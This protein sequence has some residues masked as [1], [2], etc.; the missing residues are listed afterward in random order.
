ML[1]C[2]AW[3]RILITSIGVTT[4]TASVT[5][6]ARPAVQWSNQ[7]TAH[8]MV[9]KLKSKVEQ[10]A[11]S[12]GF[13]TAPNPPSFASRGKRHTKRVSQKRAEL[14]QERSLSS[15]MPLIISKHL[16]VRLKTRKSNR[17]LRYNPRHNS[18]QSLIQSQGRLSSRN[19]QSGSYEAALLR[20]W[21]PCS[22]RE[23]HTHFDRICS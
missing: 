3:R 23:L 14:T 13:R 16:L 6:A 8:N 10:I 7:Q 12:R 5:P 17:H 9:K 21:C 4:A 18:T 22:A 15:N 2:W 1:W 11:T 19:L 20:S